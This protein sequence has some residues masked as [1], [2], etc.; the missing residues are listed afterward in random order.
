VE[1]QDEKA[2]YRFLETIRQ[3]AME[4]LLESG[5]SIEV[6][7]RHL[8]YFLQ[9]T[10]QTLEREQRIFGA[11]PDDIEWMDRMER[12]LDNLRVALE[13]STSNHPD[14][15]LDLIHTVGN[16]WVGRDYNVEAR[17]WC[18]T[19]LERGKSLSNMD[20]ERAKV[21]GI[22]G[23]SSIAIGDHKTGR[24][25]AE[26][27]IALARKVNDPIMLGRLLGLVSLACIFLGD[28]PAVEQA[29]MEAES[30]ALDGSADSLQPCSHR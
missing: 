18:Q 8:D 17:G 28:F 5:E 13:W 1:E 2:R 11:L 29:L 6:R 7:D 3:Y 24:D 10:K 4:K 19:I 20:A 25:A 21:Y 12:E 16:F 26:A 22:L 23:W 14:K 15:A 9:S 27:G 30:L